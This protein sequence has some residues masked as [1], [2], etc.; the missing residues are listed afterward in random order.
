[1]V[2]CNIAGSAGA[3]LRAQAELKVVFGL[4]YASPSVWTG[5]GTDAKWDSSNARALLQWT[6]EHKCATWLALS[7][8]LNRHRDLSAC[9]CG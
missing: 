4:D 9:A 3:I 1:M 2:Y 5:N 8:A 6:F 7:Q